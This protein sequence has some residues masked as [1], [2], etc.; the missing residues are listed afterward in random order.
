MSNTDEN[1]TCFIRLLQQS[2]ER[3]SAHIHTHNTHRILRR[4]HG[5]VNNSIIFSYY[6]ISYKHYSPSSPPPPPPPLSRLG[7]I[8]PHP[9][10]L[11]PF[12]PTCAILRG[13]PPSP[14]PHRPNK[15][16]LAQIS[17]DLFIARPPQHFS[18]NSLQLL[19]FERSFP[20]RCL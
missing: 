10:L 2:N 20:W 11:L 19:I 1:N 9:L 17:L 16:V 6:Y 14:G 8:C 5:A 13:T 3:A 7:I 18:L 4:V 15:T 12:H